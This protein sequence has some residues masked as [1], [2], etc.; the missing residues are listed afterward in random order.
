[1]K[2]Q[3][4]AVSCGLAMAAAIF[5]LVGPAYSGFD[6]N[7]TTHAT[8][9]EVNGPWAIIPVMLPVLTALL[10][11]IFHKQAVR[12]IASILIGGFA[13]IS[14]FSIGLFYLPAAITMV[15][16]TCVTPSAEISDVRQ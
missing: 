5:L 14:G 15:L 13:L 10:P 11:L 6:G 8:L 1:M 7:R 12:I 4:T 16:A 3:L 9:V 2:T